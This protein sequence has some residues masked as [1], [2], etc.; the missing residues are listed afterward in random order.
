MFAI[1]DERAVPLA[2]INQDQIAA[3][4]GMQ[5][6]AILNLTLL[7]VG[8]IHLLPLSGI[9]GVDQLNSLYGL[10]I[11]DI[12]TETLLQHRAVLF[13]LLGSFI[14][15]SIKRTDIQELALI[16]GLVSVVTFMGIVLGN[17]PVNAPIMKV[18]Y[19]DAVALVLLIIGVFAK[20]L[21][22]R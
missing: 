14:I 16:A 6:K 12:N 7:V 22:K 9:L 8:I 20:T 15:Y 19:V 21:T 5:M 4:I 17:E 18:F 2:W 13:G 1:W 3:T 10:Q 11:G